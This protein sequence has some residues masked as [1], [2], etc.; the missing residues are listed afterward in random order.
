[1][2]ENKVSMYLCTLLQYIVSTSEYL[3]VGDLEKITKEVF[4][5]DGEKIMQTIADSW[6]KEGRKEGRKQGEKK[7]KREVARKMK[8]A[9]EPI[10]KISK[11]TGFTLKQIEKL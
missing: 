6:L 1:M 8:Q 4:K 2:D 9:G 11:Y 10:E 3:K 7:G 5:E